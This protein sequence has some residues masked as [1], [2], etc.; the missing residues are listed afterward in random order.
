[1]HKGKSHL[2]G[3]T[4]IRHGCLGRPWNL[5]SQTHVFSIQKAQVSGSESPGGGLPVFWK[6]P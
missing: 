5:L 1:M 2:R 3:T 4:W 6:L